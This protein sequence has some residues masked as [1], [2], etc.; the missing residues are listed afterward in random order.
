LTAFAATATVLVAL[1]FA[2]ALS[3]ATAQERVVER[4]RARTPTIRHWGGWILI[5]AGIWFVILGVFAATFA[6]VFPV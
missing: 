1:L 4:I 2:A 3:V 5:A 6:R